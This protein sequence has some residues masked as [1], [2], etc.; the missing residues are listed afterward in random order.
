ML[1]RIAVVYL[2]L[3]LSIILL[4]AYPAQAVT[5]STVRY[6]SG[7][8]TVQGYLAV[9]QGA[10]PFPAVVVIHEWW[11]LDDWIRQNTE[12]LADQGYVALA[13]DLYR[14]RVTADPEE[15]HELM[16]GVPDDRATRDLRAAV[17]HL[18]SRS[19]VIPQKIGAIGWCMGGGYALTMALNIPD[20]AACVVNYGRLV[21]EKTSIAQ[22]GCPVLGI[23]GEED[24]GIPVMSVRAFER[25]CAEAGKSVQIVVYPGAGHAFMNENNTRGYHAEATRDAWDRIMTFL[26]KSL[27]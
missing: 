25:I 19:D 11:G 7:D 4:S 5:G 10:G 15:A 8:E 21:S 3:Y 18:K 14:G 22:I 12:R 26:A 16:R 27:K 6:K 9:P 13:V 24:R 23:F 2:L 17:A 1:R 20:L